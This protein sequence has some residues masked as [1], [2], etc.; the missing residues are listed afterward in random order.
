[1]LTLVIGLFLFLGI[2]SVRIFADPFR[3]AF[4]EAQGVGKWKG[5]Y[6]IISILGFV[7]IVVGYGQAKVENV[8]I[9]TPPLWTWHVTISLTLIAFV[10]MTSAYVPNNA[11]KAYL[12]DPMILGVKTWAFAHLI[13]QGSLAGMLMFGCFLIWA[14]FD[15]KSCRARRAGIEAIE[16][17]SS[18]LMTL[19]TL[20]VALA[21][22]VIMLFYGHALIIGIHPLSSLQA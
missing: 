3:T 5:L 21:L 9:W 2:H 19:M 1:M 14:I 17:N 4:V 8:V 20:L 15:F 13:S 16:Q 11:I 7:L 10:F 6:S 18:K 22:W 12:K